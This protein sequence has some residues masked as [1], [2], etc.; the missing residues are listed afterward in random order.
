MKKNL[1]YRD[2]IARVMHCSNVDESHREWPSGRILAFG[3][4]P[5]TSM[6]AK[7][8][9]GRKLFEDIVSQDLTKEELVSSLMGLLQDRTK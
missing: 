6:I 3:N 1:D 2:K 7:V 9:Y 4:S 8:K 5:P